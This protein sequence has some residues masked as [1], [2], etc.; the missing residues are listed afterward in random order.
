MVVKDKLSNRSLSLSVFS[1]YVILGYLLCMEH[2]FSHL[3]VIRSLPNPWNIRFHYAC[4]YLSCAKLVLKGSRAGDC[5]SSHSFKHPCDHF[6]SFPYS[7][8]SLW[9]RSHPNCVL[10]YQVKA[11]VP[12][13]QNDKVWL[14]GTSFLV[15]PRSLPSSFSVLSSWTPSPGSLT[16]PFSSEHPK[17]HISP[18]KQ[19]L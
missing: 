8:S 5:Q 17:V 19:M 16:H 11:H 2:V 18:G 7:T 10:W 4:S 15:C 9:W 12:M 1:A 3:Y 14:S 13:Q 6:I